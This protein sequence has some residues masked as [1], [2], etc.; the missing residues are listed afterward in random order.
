MLYITPR[1]HYHETR[2]QC[3]I[4]RCTA[5]SKSSMCSRWACGA[6]GRLQV[7]GRTAEKLQSHHTPSTNQHIHRHRHRG[8]YSLRLSRGVPSRP[9]RRAYAKLSGC[10][11]LYTQYASSTPIRCLLTA[12]GLT[13]NG[14]PCWRTRFA[15]L[16]RLNRRF[17]EHLR[18][19]G[20][21]HETVE[22]KSR[23]P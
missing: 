7:P 14:W 3:D 9:T 13:C 1:S 6:L 12:R 5:G 18:A 19:T 23:I 20:W 11:P 16:I 2:A 10:L 17:C 15:L 4:L 22:A 8:R 21:S